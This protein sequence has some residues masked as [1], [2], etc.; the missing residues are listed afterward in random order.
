MSYK[1]KKRR[2]RELKDYFFANVHK[3]R[4]T[5]CKRKLK[6]LEG[7][8]EAIDP[9]GNRLPRAVCRTQNCKQAGVVIGGEELRGQ[10]MEDNMA[11]LLDMEEVRV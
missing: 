8:D 11:K 9:Y 2:E 6:M 3:Q 7:T 1:A 4:C 5:V 10:F